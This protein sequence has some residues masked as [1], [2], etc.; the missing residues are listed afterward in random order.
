[1]GKSTSS[2]SYVLIYKYLI[3]LYIYLY[4]SMYTYLYLYLFTYIY[5]YIYIYIS[6]YIYI[7]IPLVSE[8]RH[9]DAVLCRTHRAG[10]DA[11]QR[12]SSVEATED[13]PSPPMSFPQFEYRDADILSRERGGAWALGWT[14][15]RKNVKTSTAC[16]TA[17]RVQ[18]NQG[19]SCDSI[20]DK[21][22]LF[23]LDLTRPTERHMYTTWRGSV[24]R[25]RWARPH[26]LSRRG[27]ASPPLARA[28][29]FHANPMHDPGIALQPT[30]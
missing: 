6:L 1:M 14:H 11:D 30:I 7:Y 3:Y 5:I 8:L 22:Y 19:R 9:N 17:S 15:G 28:T 26:P 13:T 4:I 12:K 2:L 10:F 27:A 23:P 25:R 29:G 21:A 24:Q 20:F 18:T 16:R